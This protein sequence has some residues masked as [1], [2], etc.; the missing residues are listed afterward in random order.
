[1]FRSRNLYEKRSVAYRT[2]EIAKN[3]LVARGP[4]CHALPKEAVDAAYLMPKNKIP[5]LTK[6]EWSHTG[7]PK[8]WI[9]C[10]LQKDG[11]WIIKKKEEND[12]GELMAVKRVYYKKPARKIIISTIEGSYIKI[13]HFKL[14]SIIMIR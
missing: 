9:S 7:S 10:V 14:D 2:T 8:R 5:R 13:V 11:E 6:S 1:M 4:I 3:L 12:S